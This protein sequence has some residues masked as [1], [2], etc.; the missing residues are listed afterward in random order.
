MSITMRAVRL[1][2]QAPISEDP[3]RLEDCPEPQPGTSEVRIRVT[4]CGACHTDLHIAEG[5]LPLKRSPL[6]LGHQIV[7][8]IDTVGDGVDP[9]RVG[10]RVGVPW[11][12]DSCRE[13]E[14]CRQGRE[15]L[16]R[17]ALFTGYDVDGGF[18]ELA[19][20][21]SSAAHT[22]PDGLGDA[23]AAPL[24]CAGIIGYRSLRLAELRP[25]QRLG[26]FGF[27]ASAHLAIQ[28][29]LHWGCEVFVFTR[30]E[31]HKDL[32]RSLGAAWVGG[33][34]EAPPR[35]LDAAVTFAPVAA[36]VR[37]AMG[38][39]APGGT[40][41]INA[42]HLRGT[43]ELEYDEHLYGERTLRSVTNLTHRDAE[44]FLEL[45]EQVP[46][47][48]TIEV[49]RLHEANEALRRIKSSRLD[50]AAVIVP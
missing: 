24:L 49:F 12:S 5:D 8:L 45:A 34:D 35:A 25:G 13:C 32:A 21:P 10:E 37:T 48:T 46:V 16:C 50:A 20:A 44:E 1:H 4:A 47:A 7:G 27:G 29:A 42:I 3:L 2:T 30:S 11:M 9:S 43:V 40:L 33:T 28:V 26:L 6:I 23:E 38:L 18:A 14:H 41:A 15:N 36:V 19:V 22:L 39:L 31:G 17:H